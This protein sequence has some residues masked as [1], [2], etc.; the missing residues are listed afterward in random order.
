MKL[1][2]EFHK[3]ALLKEAIDYL[4][5]KPGEVY[6][7][8]TVGGGGHSLEIL[9]RKGKVFGLDCDHEAIACAGKRLVIRQVCPLNAFRLVQANFGNLEQVL[10]DYHVTSP[11]GILF[12]LG[13]SFHQLKSKGRGFSFQ[14]DEPL[15]MR[16]DKNLK[17]TAAD[18]IAGLGPKE[19]N[20]L[21]YKLGEEKYSRA[22]AHAVLDARRKNQIKTTRQLAEIAQEVYK[23]YRVKS[24]IHP[25]TKTF[26]ALRIAVNDELNNLKDALPQASRCL[27]KRG[28][29]VIISFQGLEDEI[30]KNF[31]K[32]E[33]KNKILKILIKKPVKPGQEAIKINPNCRSAKLRAAEKL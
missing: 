31:F 29:L 3:P 28:R 7:D 11:A 32:S 20:E 16:M 23:K 17:V 30:V 12:D 8:A 4:N 2:F 25:A 19:L 21:F 6:V 13:T 1:E 22:I 14:E 24:K 10:K 33:E 9:K 5:V 18:L 27:T 26:Q 15:D